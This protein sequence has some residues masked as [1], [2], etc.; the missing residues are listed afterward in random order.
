MIVFALFS[1]GL[2]W[3]G[4]RLLGSGNLPE[5]RGPFVVA[6]LMILV[7]PLIPFGK[8][9][10]EFGSLAP[11]FIVKDSLRAVGL[12]GAIDASLIIQSE[13]GI[14]DIEADLLFYDGERAWIRRKDKPSVVEVVE[15][16]GL[17][18]LE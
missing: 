9:D 6:V 15:V 14:V 18:V 17:R 12:G 11:N 16:L 3:A 1:G 4:S 5:K 8:A 2:Y 10:S 7:F 13:R